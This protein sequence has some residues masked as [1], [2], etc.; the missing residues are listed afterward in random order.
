[1]VVSDV[2][3]NYAIDSG[4]INTSVNYKCQ[5]LIYNFTPT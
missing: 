4:S 2:L 1:M 3:L 5:S